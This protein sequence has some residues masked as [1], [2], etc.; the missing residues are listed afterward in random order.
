MRTVQPS[1]RPEITEATQ[2]PPARAGSG[3]IDCPLGWEGDLHIE[4]LIARRST[5]TWHEVWSAHVI[6]RIS[7]ALFWPA[8]LL[9]WMD[10][11]LVPASAI[12]LPSFVVKVAFMGTATLAAV[13]FLLMLLD[14]PTHRAINAY[15]EK[16]VFQRAVG[17]FSRQDAALLRRKV[18][19]SI[20]H[21]SLLAWTV[22]A[23]TSEMVIAALAVGRSIGPPTIIQLPFSAAFMTT[24]I[25]MLQFKTA[26]PAAEAA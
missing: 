22:V 9:A 5:S 15:N 21:G 17:R 26:Q 10:G 1:F 25:L 7:N 3:L 8:L 12:G 13:Y 18:L 19:G 16:A 11:V 4:E 14:R 24:V 23:L 6:N 2:G 20:K